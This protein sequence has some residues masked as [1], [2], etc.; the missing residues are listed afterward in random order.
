MTVCGSTSDYYK[1]Q[2]FPFSAYVKSSYYHLSIAGAHHVS[3]F[4]FCSDFLTHRETSAEQFG[5]NEVFVCSSD[6]NNETLLPH[7]IL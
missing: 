6:E 7:K 2:Y 1:C 3:K 5:A 4:D